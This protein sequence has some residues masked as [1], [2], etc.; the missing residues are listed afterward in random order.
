MRFSREPSELAEKHERTMKDPR[1]LLTAVLARLTL[2]AEGIG[3]LC[4]YAG[5]AAYR[6]HLWGKR[7]A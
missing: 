2:M 1:A 3:A 4:T 5:F 7:R 6:F